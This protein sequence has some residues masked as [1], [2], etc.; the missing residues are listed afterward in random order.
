MKNQPEQNIHTRQ[1]QRQYQK[2]VE[3]RRFSYKIIYFSQVSHYI[4]LF[5]FYK[6]KSI[7]SIYWVDIMLLVKT[8]QRL[9]PLLVREKQGY[10]FSLSHFQ[11]W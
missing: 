2:G 6:N 5:W 11:A 7:M 3:K 10:R 9:T 1:Y 4:I 8:Y